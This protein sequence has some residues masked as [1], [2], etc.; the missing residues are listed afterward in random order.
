MGHDRSSRGRPNPPLRSLELHKVMPRGSG[1]I[2]LYREEIMGS[3]CCTCKQ[4]ECYCMIGEIR[5]FLVQNRGATFPSTFSRK[6]LTSLCAFRLAF[7]EVMLTD[8]NAE[9]NDAALQ[10]LK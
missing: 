4:H 6:M 8:H 7:S 10:L 2:M 1:A 3:S 9:E 5:Y